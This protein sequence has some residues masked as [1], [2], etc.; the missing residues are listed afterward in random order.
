MTK[1]ELIERIKA[2]LAGDVATKHIH[3]KTTISHVLDALGAEAAVV[4]TNGHKLPLPG[5]GKLEMV[6]RAARIGRNPATGE[7]VEIPA[8]KGVRFLVS[9]MLKAAVN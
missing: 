2:R 7:P 5:I 3:E 8:H 6:E 1:N 4:L 9:K